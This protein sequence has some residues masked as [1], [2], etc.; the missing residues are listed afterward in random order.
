MPFGKLVD[1][2]EKTKP[3]RYIV[4]TSH[5]AYDKTFFEH[6]GT[7]AQRHKVAKKN[8]GVF[9]VA[10]FNSCKITVI[11]QTCNYVFAP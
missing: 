4:E 1:N 5:V 6:K 9:L 11:N 10:F 3:H 2:K 8:S 7:K